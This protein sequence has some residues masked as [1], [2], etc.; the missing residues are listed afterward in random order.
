MREQIVVGSE[1]YLENAADALLAATGILNVGAAVY[2][3][4][5]LE[6]KL[7]NEQARLSRLEETAPAPE[8]VDYICE[9]QLEDLIGASRLTQVQEAVYRLFAAGMNCRDISAT[10]GIKRQPIGF[11]LRSARQK[12]RAAYRQGRYAGWYEVYLSE[13]N[14][15]AYRNRRQP[16]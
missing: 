15:P 5:Q 13:V 14:R 7:R 16:S 6:R 1:T 11:H 4:T 10:L 9:R 8:M 3:Q 2:T 12:V